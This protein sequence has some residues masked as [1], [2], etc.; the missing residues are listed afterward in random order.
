MERVIRIVAQHVNKETGEVLD[1]VVCR[2]DAVKKPE[3]LMELGYL[4]IEQIELLSSLQDFKIKHQAVLINQSDVCP[5]CNGKARAQGI[6]K[7]TF[8]AALTDHDVLIRRKRCTC[9]WGS[10]YSLEGIY[11]ST[12]HPDLLEK[13]AIQGSENSYRKACKNLNYESKSI[14]S[15]NNVDRIRRSVSKVGEIV[16]FEK[17]QK[18][19]E[20]KKV[21][22]VD[23]LIVVVDGGHVKSNQNDSRSFEAMIATVYDPNNLKVIDKNHNEITQKTSVASA[24]SDEQKTI[25]QLVFNACRKEGIHSKVTTLTCLT[26][27]ANNCWS[28]TNTLKPYTK[29]IVNVLDWFH[30]TKRFTVINNTLNDSLKDRLTKIKWH[31][32][33]GD[34][35]TALE[36]LN[37]FIKDVT[38]EKTSEQL[39]HLYEYIKRNQKHLVNYQKR[40]AENLPFTST[41]AESSV[42]SLI[43]IRQKCNQKMQWSRVGSHNV[44]QIRTS[45]FSKS[46]FQDW[47]VAQDKIYKKVA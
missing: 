34:A 44:L 5:N 39:T 10:K 29:T 41:L 8:H 45:I 12:L 2:E 31:L 11:G 24:I 22:A 36:R 43:N 46:W 18:V 35:K 15:I 21:D 47:S 33:H 3:T 30:I 7:S 28:I 13:H 25:K 37:T 27:G 38:E 9:G 42:N 26:D 40:Q 23:N 19:N 17:L 16:A 1:S 32:W 4:H 14:R 20:V 6:I